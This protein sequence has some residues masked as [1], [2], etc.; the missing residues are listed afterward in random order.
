MDIALW[1]KIDIIACYCYIPQY[2]Y[3]YVNHYR[4]CKPWIDKPLGCLIGRVLIS[5]TF[6]HYW[7]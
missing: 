6:Y 2:C 1:I 4:Y 3:I 7:C 5:G